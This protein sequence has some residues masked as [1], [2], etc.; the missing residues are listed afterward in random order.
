MS[1][2]DGYRCAVVAGDGVVARFPGVVCLAG[3]GDPAL[4]SALIEHCQRSSGVAPGLAL[5]RRLATWLAQ[6][7]ET[8]AGLSFGT[9]AATGDDRLAVFLL[10]DMRLCTPES[11]ATISGADSAAWTDRL[12]ARPD[13]EFF[14]ARVGEDVPRSAAVSVCDLRLGVVPGVAVALLPA[15]AGPVAKTMTQPAD[16]SAAVATI[17]P[18]PAVIPS[19]E[20]SVPTPPAQPVPVLASPCRTEAIIAAPAPVRPPLPSGAPVLAEPAGGPTAQGHLCSRG[21][22]NDPRSHFCVLCGIRMEERT[23][24]LVFGPRPPLGLLVFDNGATYMVDADYLIGR[25]PE[26]D[27]RVLSGD[28]RPIAVDDTSGEVSRVHAEVRLDNWDVLISDAGSSNGTAIAAP[29]Q[30][31]T[32]LARS[33]SVRLTPGTQVRLGDSLGFVFDSPAGVR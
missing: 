7:G 1:D 8:A 31:W 14:L 10:G 3:S 20:P 33:E 19:V 30:D 17:V 9:V 23:R 6:L 26:S 11:G 4:L 29:G 16:I 21:H 28:L 32:Q 5:V 12:M 24:R 22:L 2:F 18:M 27:E 15:D 25:N 13:T